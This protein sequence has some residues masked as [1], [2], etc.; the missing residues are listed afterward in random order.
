MLLE[1]Y[2]R[3]LFPK[4]ARLGL[5]DKQKQINPSTI[6]RASLLETLNVSL[7]LPPLTSQSNLFLTLDTFPPKLRRSPSAWLLHIY[8]LQPL[9]L[10]ACVS[11][12]KQPKNT[13]TEDH[14]CIRLRS[15]FMIALTSGH[16]IA[17]ASSDIQVQSLTAAGRPRCMNTYPLPLRICDASKSSGH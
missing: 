17:S 11:C 12:G 15:T 1:M 8:S 14:G 9:A 6:I 4:Q 2:T 13:R 5:C 7:V 10:C 16:L 3:F